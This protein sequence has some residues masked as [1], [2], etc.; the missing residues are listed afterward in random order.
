[1]S[2]KFTTSI[3]L[4][5]E[6]PNTSIGGI[7]VEIFEALCPF[8]IGRRHITTFSRFVLEGKDIR[9]IHP[10]GFLLETAFTFETETQAILGL[11]EL[12]LLVLRLQQNEQQELK[13]LELSKPLPK[14]KWKKM[15]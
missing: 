12:Q 13:E 5:C 14:R 10:S 3:T 7:E 8:V 9:K 4:T 15:G 1:M 2:K 11:K 6:T